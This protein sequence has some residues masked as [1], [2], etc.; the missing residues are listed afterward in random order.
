MQFP[1]SSQGSRQRISEMTSQKADKMTQ[2]K[3]LT[4]CAFESIIRKE[5][6]RRIK[7]SS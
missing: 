7:E 2:M 5:Y 1:Y 3:E 6:I 4:I